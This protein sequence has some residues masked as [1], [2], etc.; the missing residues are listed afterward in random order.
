[1]G[2]HKTYSW[3]YGIAYNGGN[4]YKVVSRDST[5]SYKAVRVWGS[6]FGVYAFLLVPKL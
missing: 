2:F 3:G 4:P 5:W 1:M 6:R